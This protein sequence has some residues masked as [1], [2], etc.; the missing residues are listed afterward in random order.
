MQIRRVNNWPVHSEVRDKVSNLW[1]Y[2]LSHKPFLPVSSL[3]LLSTLYSYTLTD[4]IWPWSSFCLHSWFCG[5]YTAN[6]QPASFL[7]SSSLILCFPY[8]ILLSL[9]LWLNGLLEASGQT[10]LPL[11]RKVITSTA[12]LKIPAYSKYLWKMKFPSIYLRSDNINPNKLILIFF[13][14]KSLNIN[15]EPAFDNDPSTNVLISAR[16]MKQEYKKQL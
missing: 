4:G 9:S 5:Q 6:Q 11:S 2:P 3:S 16:K 13:W 14:T 8:H 10:V 12:R 1:K 15:I 7:T